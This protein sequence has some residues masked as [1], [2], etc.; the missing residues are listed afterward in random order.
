M[1]E[2]FKKVTEVTDKS[3][4][5]RTYLLILLNIKLNS[6]N[7]YL[8]FYD[9]IIKTQLVEFYYELAFFAINLIILSSLS[10]NI[11]KEYT[12]RKQSLIPGEKNYDRPGAVTGPPQK[13]ARYLEKKKKILSQVCYD[14]TQNIHLHHHHNHNNHYHHYHHH[15]HHHHCHHHE[16]HYYK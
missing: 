15:H 1:K 2:K 6:K 16:Y 13:C 5:G 11:K 4:M 12:V 10:S 14:F 3:F 7:T 9:Y 8:C